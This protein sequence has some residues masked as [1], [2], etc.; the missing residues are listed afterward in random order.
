MTEITA[1][2]FASLLI[3]NNAKL[4][5]FEVELD[6]F[7]DLGLIA[8]CLQRR[9]CAVTIHNIKPLMTVSLPDPLQAGLAERVRR[10]D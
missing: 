6:N 4:A 7:E 3:A 5:E 2:R 10:G 8:K 1:E 9:G